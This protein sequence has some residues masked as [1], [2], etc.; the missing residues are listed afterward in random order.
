L[1]DGTDSS[2]TFNYKHLTMFPN[3]TALND[4][5]VGI[6]NIIGNMGFQLYQDVMPDSQ[7]SIKF[8][9]PDVVTYQVT[10]YAIEWNQNEENAG[11]VK[12]AGDSIFFNSMV[13]NN[14]NQDVTTNVTLNMKVLNS[15]GGVEY[16]ETQTI[17]PLNVGDSIVIQFPIAFIGNSIGTFTIESSFTLG[18][19]QNPSNNV[20]LTELVMTDQ[21]SPQLVIGYGN[22]VSAGSLQWSGGN[23]GAGIYIEPPYYPFYIEGLQYEIAFATDTNGFYAQV[24]GDD[25]PFNSPGTLLVDTLINGSTI[26]IGVYTTIMLAQ[27]LEITSGGFYVAW[28]MQGGMGSIA[29]APD[30]PISNRTFEILSG[31][32]TVYRE[33]SINDFKINVISLGNCDINPIVAADG[34]TTVCLGESV[35]LVAPPGFAAYSWNNGTTTQTTVVNTTGNFFCTVMSAGGCTDVSNTL[36]ITVSDPTPTISANGNVLSCDI[37]GTYQWYFNGGLI[38]NATS[39]TYEATQTGNYAVIVTDV[40]GCTGTSMNFFLAVGM[41]E[42]RVPV[43]NMYP[44]PVVNDL[45]LEFTSVGFHEL[46][47]TD[48]SGKLVYHTVVNQ[49][50]ARIDMTAFAAGVYHLTITTDAGSVACKIAKQ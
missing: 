2:I 18:A 45:F 43:V 27:P 6:E 9:Y 29:L 48:V 50:F 17:P 28:M 21:F 49:P 13:K 5:I 16:S 46:T 35:T 10:D 47:L 20:C 12:L 42:L 26:G 44:N 8:Y 41:D 34:P 15:S 4:L 39:Q 31:T 11:I 1:L 19:D 30:A 40:N 3:V 23:A 22:G 14:G 25:G 24:W 32:W 38:A 36:S 37:T 33:R 7:F